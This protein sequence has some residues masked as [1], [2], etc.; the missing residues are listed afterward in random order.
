MKIRITGEPEQVQMLLDRLDIY[1]GSKCKYISKP[2]PQTR[3]CKTSKYVS[4]YL[5]FEDYD[6]YDLNGW[7]AEKYA[8]YS[9][10][11]QDL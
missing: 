2:Y 10:K 3:K 9:L 8:L 6:L 4:V 7:Q 11:P 1:V 5:D